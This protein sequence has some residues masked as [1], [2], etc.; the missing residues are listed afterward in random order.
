MNRRDILKTAGMAG[1]VSLFP[2]GRSRASKAAINRLQKELWLENGACV[3]IPQETAGPYPFDLSSNADMFRQ[4]ITEGNAGT[5]LNLT[6]TVVNINNNCSPV[7]NARVDI[8]HCD[9]DGYYSAY[10]NQPGYLGTRNNVGKTF[11]R[12][13]QL[14]DNNGQVTFKTIYPGWYTGRVTHIHMQVFLNS[15]L[16]ATSQMAFP[17]ALNTSVYTTS[18]YSAHGQNQIKN[19]TDNVFSDSSNTQYEMLDITDDGSGGYNASL[20]IGIAVPLT[21]VINLEPETGGQFRLEQNYPNPFGEYTTIPFTLTNP[22]HVLMELY[23]MQGRKVLQLADSRMDAGKQ[24]IRMDKRGNAA[25]LSGRSYI[26]QLTVTNENGTFR[27][28]KVLAMQ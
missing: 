19:A 18:L 4:D 25:S 8:W 5:P 14:T 16:S 10:N 26:Y 27:Q 2:F 6:L 9:K 28:C 11:F 22:S 24:E 21:G 17:D 3:L 15:L 13:I 20:T 23:D 12:G 1:I 7:Q